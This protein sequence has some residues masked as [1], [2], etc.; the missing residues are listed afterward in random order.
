MGVWYLSYGAGFSLNF[1]LF[2]FIAKHINKVYPWIGGDMRLL[3]AINL[4]M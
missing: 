3:I 2:L 1:F 4:F